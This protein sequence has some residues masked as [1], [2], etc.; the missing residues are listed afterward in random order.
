MSKK[1]DI[2]SIVLLVIL[3]GILFLVVYN[4]FNSSNTASFSNSPLNMSSTDEIIYSGDVANVIASS[5]NVNNENSNSGDVKIIN[6]KDSGEQTIIDKETTSGDNESFEEN[7]NPPSSN[8]TQFAS[9]PSNDD[10]LLITSNEEISNSEKKEI[11]KELDQT[12]MDLLDVVDKVQ[13]VDE[14]RLINEN[15]G[16]V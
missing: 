1:F 7:N 2:I 16:G 4:Y 6:E 10:T 9:I 11:L 5:K 13:T 14:T 3:I 12:L 15:E 8:A